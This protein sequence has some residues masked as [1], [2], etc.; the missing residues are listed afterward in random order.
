MPPDQ[1]SQLLTDAP[2]AVTPEPAGRSGRQSSQS[3]AKAENLDQAKPTPEARL[4]AARLYS[5]ISIVVL[6]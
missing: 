2:A 5:S 3:E 1:M 6:W 4:P